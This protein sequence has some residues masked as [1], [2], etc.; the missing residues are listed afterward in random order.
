MEIVHFI[1]SAVAAGCLAKKRTEPVVFLDALPWGRLPAGSCEVWRGFFHDRLRA[2]LP[3]W[4]KLDYEGVESIDE[5]FKYVGSFFDVLSGLEG[6]TAILWRGPSLY[7]NLFVVWIVKLWSDFGYDFSRLKI[8]HY[9]NFG[10]KDSLQIRS[11]SELSFE[12]FEMPQD[13]L[14]TLSTQEVEYL[15]SAWTML[16]QPEPS[17]FQKFQENALPVDA[18]FHDRVKLLNLHFPDPVSGLNF[19]ELALMRNLIER[20]GDLE[21]KHPLRVIGSCMAFEGDSFDRIDLDAIGKYLLNLSDLA[22]LVNPL[23]Q[24]PKE[25]LMETQGGM[26][27]LYLRVRPTEFGKQVL[28]GEKGHLV[29]NPYRVSICGFHLNQ[30]SPTKW[31]NKGGKLFKDIH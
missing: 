9:T 23:D 1:Y 26:P 19:W 6:K 24:V 22:H 30:S 28:K 20:S 21:W 3:E 10:R 25:P 15:L 27:L 13:K 4:W 11:L 5:I 8:N 12:D 31:W 17:S 14:R 7:E 29:V 18:E 16:N 2:E